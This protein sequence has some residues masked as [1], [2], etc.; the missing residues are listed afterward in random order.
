MLFE[1]AP[2]RHTSLERV[3]EGLLETYLEHKHHAVDDASEESPSSTRNSTS[4]SSAAYR[5]C[6][7][8]SGRESQSDRWSDLSTYS[9]RTSA[10]T[11]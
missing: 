4:A 7:A 8:D 11:R 1:A 5:N 9:R 3:A 10:T 2:Q 6:S